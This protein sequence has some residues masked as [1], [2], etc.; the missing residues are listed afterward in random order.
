MI[1]KRI[2]GESLVESTKLKYIYDWEVLST[3]S[4]PHFNV[5]ISTWIKKN[6]IVIK[7]KKLNQN[8][9]QMF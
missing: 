6:K 1:N 5:T 8:I 3:S 2:V 7:L 4:V 9:L